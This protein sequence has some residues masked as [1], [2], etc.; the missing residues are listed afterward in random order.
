MRQHAGHRSQQMGSCIEYRGFRNLQVTVDGKEI[1][2][3]QAKRLMTNGGCWVREADAFWSAS[4]PMGHWMS[5]PMLAYESP[6]SVVRRFLGAIACH[7]E[8]STAG[9]LIVATHSG[10]IRALVAWAAGSD[11][12]EPENVEEV[13]VRTHQ[14]G[15]QLRVSFRGQSWSVAMPDGL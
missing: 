4:D 11:L 8:R 2:P 7:V 15:S 1:E 12:G 3:T 13:E 14:D 9:H 6:Q 10:C 5:T